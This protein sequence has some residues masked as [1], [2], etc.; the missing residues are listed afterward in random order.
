MADL[1]TQ[2]RP[3]VSALLTKD[4]DQLYAELAGRVKA[5]TIN[6]SMSASFSPQLPQ[7]ES[8]GT[9][10]DLQAFGKA[11]FDRLNGQ[12]YGLVCG[13]DNA[14]A[15]ERQKIIDAFGLGS[16][17][18]AA[19]IAG[20]LVA[21]LAMAPAVATVVGALAVKLFFR[22][23]HGAMCDFWKTKLPQATG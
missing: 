6:P 13:T 9:V 14:N 11:F 4:T 16:D 7:L 3:A 22:T 5:M 19:A 12:V 18:V 21:S 20:T 23:A 10:D 15:V 2:A 8:L 17:A 1:T